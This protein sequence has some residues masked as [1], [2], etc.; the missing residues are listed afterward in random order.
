MSEPIR[1][2]DSL[3]T[4]QQLGESFA[5]LLGGHDWQIDQIPEALPVDDAESPLPAPM[6]EAPV[7]EAVN[8][9]TVP[10]SPL[11]IIEALL[12]VGGQPLKSEHAEEVIR[13]LTHEQFRE[14]VESLNRLYRA[15][16]RPY[17][18]L[19]GSQGY[20]LRILPRYSTIRE[21][22]FGGPREARLNQSAL[23]VVSL[24]AY[25]QP[26]P[27]SEIDNLR[28]VESGGVVRQLVRLGLI[29]LAGTANGESL[30]ATT[31]RFLEVFRVRSI[32]DLPELGEAKRI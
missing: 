29:S 2:D 15:Q 11:Q 18:I 23:D 21:R 4:A 32:E 9:A 26:I 5:V 19:R 17:Q 10:P 25:R 27:K 8:E 24:I 12:F 6:A 3:A 16:N 13:G 1:E 14:T 30:Y 7:A 28:G 31:E 22:L 20:S